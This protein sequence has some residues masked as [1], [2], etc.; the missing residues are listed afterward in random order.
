M[1]PTSVGGY[2]EAARLASMGFWVRDLKTSAF[3][4]L[5]NTDLAGVVF[6]VF[7]K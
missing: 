3:P 2:S 7:G 6:A 4:T 5:G 1:E